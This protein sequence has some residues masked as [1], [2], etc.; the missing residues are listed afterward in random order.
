LQAAGKKIAELHPE[1]ID[2]LI[3]NAGIG[4]KGV[5]ATEL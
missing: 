2:V 1:G 3:N 5:R 4:G